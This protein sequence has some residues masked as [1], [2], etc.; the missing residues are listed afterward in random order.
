MEVRDS[1]RAAFEESMRRS[2]ETNL[3][4]HS[5]GQV[6]PIYETNLAQLRERGDHAPVSF[7]ILS[8]PPPPD[9]RVVSSHG[10]A[11]RNAPSRPPSVVG[12]VAARHHA[13]SMPPLHTAVRD[14]DREEVLRLVAAGADI[15]E[16]WRGVSPLDLAVMNGNTEVMRWM[17]HNATDSYHGHECD[18][19]YT[20][21]FAGEDFGEVSMVRHC[22]EQKSISV[23]VM[24]D[25][26][27]EKWN[28][29]WGRAASFSGTRGR[30]VVVFST[31]TYRRKIE[32]NP[33]GALAREFSYIREHNLNAIVLRGNMGRELPDA[34]TLDG[35]LT[36]QVA[37]PL[38]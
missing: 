38:V 22:L 33:N 15:N 37:R 21:S 14:Q 4:Q 32:K 20:F 28:Q 24:N 5:S 18:T 17:K 27:V 12:S 6:A 26:R 8:A 30:G 13:T 36:S 29:N 23:H 19:D 11:A 9:R 2:I 16:K 34:L 35:L 3:A 10:A 25:E 31:D 7:A 1:E